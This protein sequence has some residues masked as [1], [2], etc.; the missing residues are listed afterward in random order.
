MSIG[1]SVTVSVPTV[2]TTVYTLDKA[3]D[4]Q[5][6]DITS[7][8]NSNG[9]VI[10]ITLTLQKS[11]IAGNRRTFGLVLRH[12]PAMYDSVLGAAQGAITVSVNVS[13]AVGAGFD[14]S[15]VQDFVQYMASVIA[16]SG[17]INALR[18]GSYA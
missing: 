10:P 11:S 13:A 2:G 7:I 16:Q 15:N 5:Y 14:A 6:Q 4:G 12:K 3:Y 17:I 9:D 8:T 1:S 18:D